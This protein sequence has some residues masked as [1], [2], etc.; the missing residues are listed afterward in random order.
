MRSPPATNRTQSN[1]HCIHLQYIYMLVTSSQIASIYLSVQNHN[2]AVKVVQPR[3]LDLSIQRQGPGSKTYFSSQSPG[4]T[5]NRNAS[6][7]LNRPQSTMSSSE[8][9]PPPSPQ[10]VPASPEELSRFQ[11]LLVQIHSRFPDNETGREMSSQIAQRLQAEFEHPKHSQLELVLRERFTPAHA[12]QFLF[13]PTYQ[14]TKLYPMCISDPPAGAPKDHPQRT[15]QASYLAM[16]FLH[17]FHQ[18]EF[19]IEFVKNGGLVVLAEM[20]AHKNLYIR[21]Q[22]A[23]SLTLITSCPELDWFDEATQS[24]DVV[25][26]KRKREMRKYLLKL[27]ETSFVKG[28]LENLTDSFPGGSFLCLQVRHTDDWDGLDWVGWIG[29]DWIG[30]GGLMDGWMDGWID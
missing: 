27:T 16:A 29:L 30:L 8:T 2:G 14:D 24:E 1:N 21:G 20:V 13:F 12:R 15:V 5:T 7:N 22:V 19:C 4:S 28:L 18:G 17:H 26:N 23:E 11:E 10:P 6:F 9:T 25:A 3:G